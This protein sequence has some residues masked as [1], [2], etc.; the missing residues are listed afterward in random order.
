M[1]AISANF[2]AVNKD[3]TA[4]ITLPCRVKIDGP[5]MLLDINLSSIRIRPDLVIVPT[6][7]T[8]VTKYLCLGWVFFFR[9]ISTF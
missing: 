8:K 4:E 6:F 7:D 3:V 2:I 5:K 9:Q 1:K